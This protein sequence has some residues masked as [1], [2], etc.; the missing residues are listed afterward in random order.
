MPPK[1]T[2]VAPVK[3]VPVMVTDVPEAPEVGLK[4]L[5][6]GAAI[7]EELYT[8]ELEIVIVLLV[9]VPSV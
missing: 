8:N 6:V 2:T 9:I 3:L 1:L 4:P 5:I 7:P